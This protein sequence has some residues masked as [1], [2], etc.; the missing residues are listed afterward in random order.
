EAR[1]LQIA[2]NIPAYRAALD[3]ALAKYPDDEELWLARGQAESEDPEERG[4]GSAAG[5][6]RFYEKALALAPAHFAA[7]HYLTHAYENS[8]RIQEALTRGATYAKMAPGVPHARHMLGHNLRRVG[9]I[10]EAIGE[11]RA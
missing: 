11:F 9:R 4:Q 8:G 3:A 5:S 1:A 2:K 10:G 6:I 7:Q